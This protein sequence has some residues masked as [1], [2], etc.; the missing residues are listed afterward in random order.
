MLKVV[1]ITGE[2]FLFGGQEQFI[3]NLVQYM[4]RQDLVID[5]LTPYQCENQSFQHLIEKKGGQVT[6]LD[7]PFAPGKSRKFLFREVYEALKGKKYD[8]AHIHSGSVSALAYLS[9]AA[10][11]AGIKRILVHSHC[12]GEKT[13]KHAAA[14]AIFG[15][16]IKK[17]ATDYLACSYQAGEM[18]Y[19][20]RI[21]R[22]RLIVIHNGIPVSKF[23][24]N[25]DIRVQVRNR[26]EIGDNT[27]VVGHVGRFSY[28]KNHSFLIKVFNDF[29]NEIKDSC[30]LLV[31]DGELLADVQ[32]QIKRLNLEKRVV[33]VG[34]V[35]NPEDYYQ[36]M[37][38][39]LFPSFFE[40]LGYVMLE[41]QAAGLP[42]IASDAVPESVILSERAYR[43]SLNDKDQWIQ[44]MK[45]NM[46]AIRMD[47]RKI[48]K[49]AGYD[50]DYTIKQIESLYQIHKE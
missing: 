36:A 44:K 22:E 19:P 45:E 41:A 11:A 49:E 25:A 9:K 37:D 16:V 39:F 23:Q 33:I 42:C 26:L 21:V 34:N 32:E 13:L 4:N 18:K 14:K 24:Y 47:S 1:E 40:G 27:F 6:A 48:L 2:P 15:N 50:I 29:R 28:Q 31:G 10:R 5:V 12:T 46:R 17:N 3:M 43:L 8:I 20:A 35:N 7:L 38:L 30:L